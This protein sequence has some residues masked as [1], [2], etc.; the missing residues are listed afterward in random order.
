VTR[1]GPDVASIPLLINL[2]SQKTV[3]KQEFIQLLGG[4]CTCKSEHIPE[5]EETFSKMARTTIVGLNAEYHER[6]ARFLRSVQAE[7]GGPP[8]GLT[9]ERIVEILVQSAEGAKHDAKAQGDRE[10]LE[11][12]LQEWR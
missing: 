11:R 2:S 1:S 12:R 5:L 10:L 4:R 8:L 3:K 7:I 6:L 9:V